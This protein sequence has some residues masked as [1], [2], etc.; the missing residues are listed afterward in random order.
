[1]IWTEEMLNKLKELN[2]QKIP[3]SIMATVLGVT[4]NAVGGMRGRLIAAGE[5]ERTRNSPSGRPRKP[6]KTQRV[7]PGVY[8]A[9]PRRTATI[10]SRRIPFQDL[11]EEHCLAVMDEKYDG[12]WPVYCGLPRWDHAWCEAHAARYYYQGWRR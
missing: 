1:M 8:R 2:E 10:E 7:A 12:I 3:Q 4:R 11:T 6:T 9:R 5:L